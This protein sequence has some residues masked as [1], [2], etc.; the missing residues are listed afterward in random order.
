MNTRP[1]QPWHLLFC[2]LSL[3]GAVVT[4][5]CQITEGGQTLPSPYYIDD[6]V[7]YFAPHTE[8]KLSRE[9]ATLKT[10]KEAEA[11]NRLNP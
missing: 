7:Q 5:G 2:G 3:V 8:F 9:A 11:A 1:A 4:T 10:F 6:D